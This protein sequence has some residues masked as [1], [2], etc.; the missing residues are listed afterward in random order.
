MQGRIV[1][2]NCCHRVCAI[3]ALWSFFSPSNIPGYEYEIRDST[4]SRVASTKL[5]TKLDSSVSH[6]QLFYGH[7]RL[8][9]PIARTEV[10]CVRHGSSSWLELFTRP[11]DLLFV[12]A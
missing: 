12:D 4:C 3:N 6:R 9:C 5:S 7:D 10:D 8:G 11:C 1:P 2:R